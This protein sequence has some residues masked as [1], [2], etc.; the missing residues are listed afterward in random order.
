MESAEN[1]SI[2]VRR[3]LMAEKRTHSNTPLVL[4]S[5]NGSPM[6]GATL[7]ETLYQLGIVPSRSRA[8][9]SNDNA[10]AESVFKTCKYRPGFPTKG[11][12]SITTAREWV[13]SFVKWYNQEHRHSG[14]NFLTPKQRHECQSKQVFSKRKDVYEAAKKAH[15]ERW[16]RNIRKWEIDERVWLNPERV[17]QE[18]EEEEKLS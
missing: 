14:L 8:R 3:A 13:L 10:Y 15:P 17:P 6:K 9:V 4:H 11:F 16:S 1:A 7:L 5:D 12:E 18:K 2:L